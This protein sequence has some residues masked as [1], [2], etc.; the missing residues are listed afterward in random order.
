MIFHLTQFMNFH[1]L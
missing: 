1:N